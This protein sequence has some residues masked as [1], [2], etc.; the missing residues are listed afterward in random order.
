[1]EIIL[2]EIEG[3]LVKNRPLEVKINKD[4]SSDLEISNY[5][6]GR[7]LEKKIEGG[8]EYYVILGE[9]IEYL[10]NISDNKLND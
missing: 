3:N 2:K 10:E 4:K 9:A 5:E 8:E 1:M 7:T 6:I